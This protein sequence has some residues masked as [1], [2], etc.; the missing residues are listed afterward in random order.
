MDDAQAAGADGAESPTAAP[1]IRGRG[2]WW[3]DRYDGS[4]IQ[5]L[6]EAFGDV[7]FGNWIVLFGASFLLS[8]LPLIL[9]LSAFANSRVDDDIGTRLGLNQHG[10][11]IVESLFKSAHAGWGF[12]VAL[13]LVFSLAGTIAVARQIQKLYLRIFG[14]P[15]VKGWANVLRCLVWPLA[16]ALEVFV[17]ARISPPLRA[18]P[19]GRVFLGLGNL[20]IA[21]ALFWWG[22]HWLLLGKESWRRLIPAGLATGVF[23]VGLGAF[24]SFYFPSTLTSDSRLYGAIGVV[25]DLVTWFVAMGAVIALGALAGHIFVTRTGSPATTAPGPVD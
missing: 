22:L 4:A 12:G 17:D 23:W 9:L 19:G 13:A 15:D 2:Q 25:F 24:A 3:R 8:V 1:R 21:T 6:V 7:E 10:A 11:H 14:Y 16:A 5:D 20:V 18:L